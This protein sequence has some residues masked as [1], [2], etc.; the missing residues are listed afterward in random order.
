MGCQTCNQN[1][2]NNTVIPL[3]QQSSQSTSAYEDAK[4]KI[5]EGT[6]IGSSPAGITLKTS[7]I[8][9]GKIINP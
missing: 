5:I 1:K 6:K 3:R 2:Q 9:G 8:I 4:R 7:K